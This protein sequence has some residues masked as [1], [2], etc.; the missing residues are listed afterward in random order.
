MSKKNNK[1]GIFILGAAVGTGIGML[2][3]P[4]KGSETREMLKAKMDELLIN[5]KEIDVNEVKKNIED[6]IKEIQ[7]EIKTLDKEKVLK[8]AKEQG[9]KIQVKT[10][11][12]VDLAK[13]KGTPV[14]Q[15]LALNI[16]TKTDDVIKENITKLEKSKE[17]TTPTPK[18]KK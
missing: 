8:I 9:K 15:D 4:R 14:L 11:E 10:K 2:F 7:E 13:S 18:T 6:K 12:L 16:M 3:A 17:K 1:L 5:L